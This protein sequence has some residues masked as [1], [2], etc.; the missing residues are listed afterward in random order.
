MVKKPTPLLPLAPPPPPTPIQQTATPAPP[1]STQLQQPHQQAISSGVCAIP[2]SS[3]VG[4]KLHTSPAPAV[5]GARSVTHIAAAVAGVVTKAIVVPVSHTFATSNFKFHYNKHQAPDRQH[6]LWVAVDSMLVAYCRHRNIPNQF[7]DD[8]GRRLER[9]AFL[10]AHELLDD[11]PAACERLWTSVE[12]MCP[13]HPLEL[14]S[15]LNAVIR[16]DID[17]QVA[18]AA[19]LVRG[20]N[21][22]CVTRSRPGGIPFPPGGETWRGGGFDDTHRAF[23]AVGTLYRAPGFVASSFD[24]EKAFEF[25]YRAVHHS[26]R[27]GVLWTIRVDPRGETSLRYRCKQANLV[28]R[29]APGVPDEQE[30]LFAPYSAF[31]VVEVHWEQNP[32]DR[33]PHRIVVEAIIDNRD[34][35][36]DIML[37]P[38]F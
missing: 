12:T 38:W 27:P 2:S 3:G 22:L 31:R 9:G 33:T 4:T 28:M 1:S 29:R 23:F 32:D 17:E 11:V 14:C 34:A 7:G 8:F 25:L 19:V 37:A 15:I 36:E 5:I 20:I 30:Y 13:G 26:N 35:P 6:K 18:H 10:N 21:Q 16:E 24:Q